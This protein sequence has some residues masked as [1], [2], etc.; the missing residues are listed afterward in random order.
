S[1]EETWGI[2]NYRLGYTKLINHGIHQYPIQHGEIRITRL[3]RQHSLQA[4]EFLVDEIID[5]RQR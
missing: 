4:G 2:P 5:D 1:L 3:R